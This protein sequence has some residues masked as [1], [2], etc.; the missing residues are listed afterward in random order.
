MKFQEDPLENALICISQSGHG[1]VGCSDFHLRSVMRRLH[2]AANEKT[3]DL[4]EFNAATG[5][6]LKRLARDLEKLRVGIVGSTDTGILANLLDLA[7]LIGG[8][9][10]IHRLDLTLVDQCATPLKIC[11]AFADRFGVALKTQ[12]LDFL[13]GS[14]AGQFDLIL[15]HGVVP[16]FP[17]DQR[18]AYLRHIATW[19]SDGGILL[20]S[21]H[22]GT[23]PYQNTDSVRTQ[24]AVDNLKDMAAQN[25]LPERPSL[26]TLI[27]RLVASRETQ[28]VET[29]V[30]PDSDSVISAFEAAAL[31]VNSHWVV[32]LDGGKAAKN[33]RR[34]KH[35]S[36]VTC[37]RAH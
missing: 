13:Q 24:M 17:V 15:M 27:Q 16:F 37:V 2:V 30:F 11:E 4:E 3:G 9:D 6:A 19:L 29:T 32:R 31:K 33:F 36:I 35:R 18:P 14:Y 25:L 10:L 1:C 8:N 22:L 26:A 34:Y 21:T 12:Q 23:K 5:V 7:H 28:S 20:S